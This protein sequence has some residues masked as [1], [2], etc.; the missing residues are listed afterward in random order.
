[1]RQA[2]PS[3]PRSAELGP[4]WGL[5]NF[6][7]GALEAGRHTGYQDSLSD[8]VERLL[9]GVERLLT[10]ATTQSEAGQQL[11]VRQVFGSLPC[12]LHVLLGIRA[13]WPASVSA[14]RQLRVGA[15]AVEGL[16]TSA[17]AQ[18]GPCKQLDVRQVS[19]SLSCLLH[20]LLGIRATWPASVPAQRQLRVAA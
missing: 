17:T 7:G 16:L 1:M 8:E 10:S 15:P 11:E 4:Q 14:Q 3:N 20:V 6:P 9:T 2:R 18:S 5:H 13:T 12:L 19:G